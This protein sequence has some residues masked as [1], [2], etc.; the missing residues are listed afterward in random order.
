MGETS[1][2]SQFFFN[3]FEISANI[4]KPTK[5]QYIAISSLLFEIWDLLLK[6][7]TL[8]YQSNAMFYNSKNVCFYLYICHKLNPVE[9]LVLVFYYKTIFMLFRFTSYNNFQTY[10]LQLF[11][12]NPKT[13]HLKEISGKNK[14]TRSLICFQKFFLV[15]IYLQ[16]TWKNF[17]LASFLN[18]F[19]LSFFL[20]CL[21]LL[22][23]FQVLELSE[24]WMT[25]FSSY[26]LLGVIKNL[27][28][29]WLTNFHC[30]EKFMK[31]N[32]FRGG[33]WHEFLGFSPKWS[34][35]KMSKLKPSD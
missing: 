11:E 8:N 31:N 15:M 22:E 5:Y 23:K 12:H 21:I 29:T 25:F 7:I 9:M 20:S 3:I 6:V 24:R 2:S 10:L 19:F 16:T 28:A 27:M 4:K 17:S 32:L 13:V 1:F 33:F 18:L 35:G 30:Q 26:L 34:Q 14:S